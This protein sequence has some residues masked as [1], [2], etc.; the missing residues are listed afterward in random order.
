LSSNKNKLPYLEIILTAVFAAILSTAGTYFI[1][2][3]KVDFTKEEILYK[4]KIQT[5]KEFLAKT[6]IRTKSMISELLSIGALYDTVLT[7]GDIQSFEHKMFLFIEKYDFQ[8]IYLMLENDFLRLQVFGGKKVKHY[9]NDILFVISNRAYLVDMTQYPKYVKNTFKD[10][11]NNKTAYG[12]DK[13]VHS[14][15]RLKIVLLNQLFKLLLNHI[16][17]NILPTY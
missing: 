12:Y 3:K 9:C 1:E 11:D 4:N 14:E 13:E 2:S 15:D 5:Y 10:L 8:D 16:N 17:T 7:D 6:D